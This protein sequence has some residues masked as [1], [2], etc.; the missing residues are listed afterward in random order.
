MRCGVQMI[1]S[2]AGNGFPRDAVGKLE[3]LAGRVGRMAGHLHE[4]ECGQSLI[5]ALWS[6][7]SFV[8]HLRTCPPKLDVRG[9]PHPDIRL[10]CK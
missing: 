1:R 2:G 10:W 8:G 7:G 5:G 9:S 3:A 4:A 6:M